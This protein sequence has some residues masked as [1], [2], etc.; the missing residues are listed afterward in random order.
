MTE[1]EMSLEQRRV[2][3]ARALDRLD[4]VLARDLVADPGLVD[5]VIQRF[6]FCIELCWRM[7]KA[8]LRLEEVEA[9]SPRATLREAYKMSWI[10]DEAM[11]L[12]MLDDRNLTPHT[13]KEEV[14]LDVLSRIPGYRDAMRAV[15]N[16]P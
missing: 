12:K 5:S 1:D 11:W 9:T 7:L 2:I 16:A 13:Y 6:E 3:R 4:H 8:A 14:A 15:L 10:D